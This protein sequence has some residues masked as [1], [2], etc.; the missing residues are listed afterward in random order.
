MRFPPDLYKALGRS[1]TLHGR[2]ANAQAVEYVRN[3]L[4]REG[5]LAP[6]ATHR[7]GVAYAKFMDQHGRPPARLRVSMADALSSCP[8]YPPAT[9]GMNHEWRWRGVPMTIDPS[10]TEPV[11]EDKA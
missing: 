9:D 7:I 6:I 5:L 2:T 3:G 4:Q 10:V 11:A 8:E 1:A